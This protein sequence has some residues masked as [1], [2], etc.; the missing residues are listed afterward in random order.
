RKGIHT[1]T[2][3]AQQQASGAP[4]GQGRQDLYLRYAAGSQDARGAVRRA[5]PADRLSLHAGPGM[6]RGLPRV[7]VSLGQYR[8]RVAASRASRRFVYGR[9][10]R[11][12]REDRRV[13]KA[14]G[15]ALSLGL[16]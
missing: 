1:R 15:L 5:Q 9:F 2:R 12:A 14:H 11:T 13:Q 8:W 6:E 16:V 3:R 7:L 10:A 4:M